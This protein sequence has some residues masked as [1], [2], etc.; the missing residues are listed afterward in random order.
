MFTS[1]TMLML[2]ACSSLRWCFCPSIFYL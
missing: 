1:S 2:L